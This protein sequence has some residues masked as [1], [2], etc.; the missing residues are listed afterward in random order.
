MNLKQLH[1]FVTI[2][3]EGT[4]NGAAKK[5]FVSQPPLSAQIKLLEDEF[6]CI[7]F[8]RGQRQ[9]QL[10][11]AGK[12]LYDKATVLLEISRITQEEMRECAAEEAGTI[13][14][15]IV[16]SVVCSMGTA[17]IADFMKQ[18][19]GVRFEVYEANTYE[20]IDKIRSDILHIAVI[21]TPYTAMDME[22]KPLK[23]EA[24]VSI[25][26]PS[27]FPDSRATV[28]LK[29]LS[30]LP[31][32]L[33]RRWEKVIKS[34]FENARIPVYFKCVCDDARTLTALAGQGA[35]IGLVPASVTDMLTDSEIICKPIE[36]CFIESRI[37]LIYKE[38]TYLPDCVTEFTEYLN[39]K[40][41]T[42]PGKK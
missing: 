15:G 41:L 6:G 9:I 42:Y 19:P 8:R 33:Y 23:S 3:E 38:N 7:L 30:A 25:G 37:D 24:L 18:H 5:L 28:S 21:R 20:L 31:I 12:K 14:I 29:D 22:I 4:I 34:Q 11:D 32:I 27:L 35:G 40:F 17:W 10:T 36:D 16:S 13:R 1:Y 39:Q 2:V 26:L